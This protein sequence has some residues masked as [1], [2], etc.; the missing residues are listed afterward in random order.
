MGK[1]RGGES[2]KQE[3]QDTWLMSLYVSIKLTLS[4]RMG[5]SL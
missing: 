4:F 1:G 3:E 2:G 5:A